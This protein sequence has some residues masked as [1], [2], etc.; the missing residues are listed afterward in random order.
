MFV[1]VSI[2]TFNG[3]GRSVRDRLNS[4]RRCTE[5]SSDGNSK[6]GVVQHDT[7][8]PPVNTH[9]GNEVVTTL[10]PG[11]YTFRHDKSDRN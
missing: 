1:C 6:M 2:Y 7:T 3:E 4:N 5:G 9:L 11:K 10:K 8:W